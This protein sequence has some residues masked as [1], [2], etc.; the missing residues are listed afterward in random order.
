MDN[1]GKRALSIYDKSNRV[2][3]QSELTTL[4]VQA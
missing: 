3:K 4:E 2:M 1:L